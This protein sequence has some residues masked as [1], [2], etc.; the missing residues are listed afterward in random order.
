M[1][2]VFIEKFRELRSGKRTAIKRCY[3]WEVF[4]EIVIF[5]HKPNIYTITQ[6]IFKRQ[7]HTRKHITYLVV[8]VLLVVYI[9][10]IQSMHKHITDDE[11]QATIFFFLL[12]F[13]KIGN[14]YKIMICS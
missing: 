3:Y 2:I 1:K 13:R 8:L 11:Y 7:T 6:F 5:K 9:I 10:V 14:V 4:R 12:I